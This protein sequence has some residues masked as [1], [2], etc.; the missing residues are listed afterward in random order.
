MKQFGTLML[1]NH[2]EMAAIAGNS[3]GV[4]CITLLPVPYSF[5]WKSPFIQSPLHPRTAVHISSKKPY[6][7]L[8]LLAFPL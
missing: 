7:K 6:L 4:F 3:T 2:F 8:S 1:A 5:P